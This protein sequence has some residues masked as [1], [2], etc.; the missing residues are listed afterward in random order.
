M[1]TKFLCVF[2]NGEVSCIDKDTFEDL[3]SECLYEGTNSWDENREGVTETW[4][5]G[6]TFK[7]IKLRF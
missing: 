4:G 5:N 2:E 7:L 6:N 3:K 1:I